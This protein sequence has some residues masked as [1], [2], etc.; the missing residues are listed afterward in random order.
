MNLELSPADLAFQAEVRAFLAMHLTDALREG[1]RG[2]TS[3][4][5]EPEV[6]GPWQRVLQVQG[7]LVPLWPEEW[8]G[9]GWTAL[10]RFIF[11]TECA[12]AG[13]PLV[14]PMG[15]RLV[16]PVILRFGTQAQKSLYLPRILS[17]EDY[18]CQ[19]FSEPGAGSDLASLSLRARPDGDDYVLDG[20][21]IWTTQAHHANRMFALVRTSTEGK[22]QQ[23]ISFL[24]IDMASP[25][26]TVRPIATIG[27]DH[28]VNEVHFDGVRVP[29]ADRIGEENAGWECAKYL[30]EFERGAGIFSPRLRSQLKRVAEA[31]ASSAD[32]V[33]SE[34]MQRRFGEVVSDLDTFEWLEMRTMAA[35][36]PGDNPGPV[37]S[38]LKLRASRLKQEIGELGVDALGAAGLRWRSAPPDGPGL[39]ATLVPEYCNSR[40]FT[41]FGGAAEI[42][43]GLIGKTVLG[44]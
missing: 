15:V 41:I 30:L 8:G 10:Q 40:A 28:D 29:Q 9:T 11:E 33:L 6:S 17:G 7:W 43:L 24:L 34:G 3:M 36:P 19:G 20:T 44:L 26:I 21:K 5:P 37:S 14:H 2:T 38:I 12:L 35:L 22:R 18:W 1:Q 42:Q 4:Y 25:G 27:G 39:A 13:A 16:G 32:Q 31:M 23:G